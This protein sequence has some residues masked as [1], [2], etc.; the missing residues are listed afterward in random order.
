MQ[1]KE[2]SHRQL[3]DLSDSD[4]L[5]K[6]LKLTLGWNCKINSQ[7]WLSLFGLIYLKYRGVNKVFPLRTGCK[8]SL[9]KALTFFFDLTHFWVTL[10][11]FW[12]SLRSWMQKLLSKYSATNGF[13]NKSTLSLMIFSA[14]FFFLLYFCPFVLKPVDFINFSLYFGLV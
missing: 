11:A 1:W 12:G 3:I 7:A 4:F 14:K 5:G 9:T 6:I 13:F 10:Y 2:N 8:E